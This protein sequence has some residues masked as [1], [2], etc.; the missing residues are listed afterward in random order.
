MNKTYL[1]LA[2][3]AKEGPVKIGIARNIPARLSALQT[4]CPYLIQYV[5]GWRFG[6]RNKAREAES[7][8]LH[9]MDIYG[10]VGEWVRKPPLWTYEYARDVLAS[11]GFIEFEDPPKP[12][13][14]T[15]VAIDDLP[16]LA[17]IVG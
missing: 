11:V 17:E 8:V 9:E 12:H 15:L 7:L 5:G 13:I 14:G 6:T 10:L 4:G 2:A 1:Y 16:S 3:Y